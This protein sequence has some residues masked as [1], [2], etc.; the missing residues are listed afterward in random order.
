MHDGKSDEEKIHI[1]D[2]FC[3]LVEDLQSLYKEDLVS[4]ITKETI[5]NHLKTCEKCQRAYDDELV[6]GDHLKDDDDNPKETIDYF[7]R[8]KK[9]LFIRPILYALITLI[10]ASVGFIFFFWGII[11]VNQAQ[12]DIQVYAEKELNQEDGE[13]YSYHVTFKISLEEGKVLNAR[14]YYLSS[15]PSTRFRGIRLYQ[16]FKIPFDDRGEHPN[17][18]TYTYGTDSPFDEDDIVVFDFKDGRVVYSLKEIAEDA[19]IQ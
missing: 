5:N 10:L 4:D 7:K 17:T 13:H 3:S 12:A 19:G 14:N 11:P 2:Q 6:M 15:D 9:A 1:Q 18:M 16:V 8:V